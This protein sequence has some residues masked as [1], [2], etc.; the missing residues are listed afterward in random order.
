MTNDATLNCLAIVL[1][2]VTASFMTTAELTQVAVLSLAL[3]F[4]LVLLAQAFLEAAVA[5]VCTVHPAVNNGHVSVYKNVNRWWNDVICS[6]VVKSKL[7]TGVS[8]TEDD[9]ANAVRK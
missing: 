6:T 4:L 2:L 8:A 1:R 3:T 5:S 7:R 9:S